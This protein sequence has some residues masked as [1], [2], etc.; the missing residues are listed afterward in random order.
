MSEIYTGVHFKT[1]FR[2]REAPRNPE[3]QILMQWCHHFAD[4]G[5]APKRDNGYAGNLSFRTENGFIITAAGADLGNL[6]G[7]DLVQVTDANRDHNSVTVDGK[8]EPSSESFLH[9]A[10]YAARPQAQAVFHGHDQ[11]VLRYG[12]NMHLPVTAREQPYGTLDLV[13]EI[14]QVL[15]NH[16]YIV[17]RNHGFIALGSDMDQAGQEALEKHQLARQYADS[18]AG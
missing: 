7:D 9:H 18:A 17:I 5:L 1:I 8:K 4:Q 15:D 16:S 11:L 3:T 10:I 6:G 14:M 12:Q 13:D 2:T